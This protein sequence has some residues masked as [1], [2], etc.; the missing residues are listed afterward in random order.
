MGPLLL[1]QQKQQQNITVRHRLKVSEFHL[2]GCF[3]NQEVHHH[4][5]LS[6]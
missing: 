6:V 1:L 3:L 4:L 5:V 2:R